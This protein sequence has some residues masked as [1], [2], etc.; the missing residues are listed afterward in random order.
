MTEC[1]TSFIC[2]CEISTATPFVLPG[3]LN[4]PIGPAITI[5]A[6]GAQLDLNGFTLT[7]DISNP[8]GTDMGIL[9]EN[10][11]DVSVYNGFIKGFSFGIQG[12]GLDGALFDNISFET[13]ENALVIFDSEDIKVRNSNFLAS[14]FSAGG[15]GVNLFNVNDSVVTNN[16]FTMSDTETTGVIIDNSKKALVNLNT[17]FFPSTGFIGGEP[18]TEFNAGVEV[19]DSTD[20]TVLRNCFFGPADGTILPRTQGVN[21]DNEGL[22]AGNNDVDIVGNSFNTLD[23][24]IK[25]ESDEGTN[26]SNNCLTN[27]NAAIALTE[28][29][30]DFKLSKNDFFNN[31]ADVLLGDG[32]VIVG[33]PVKSPKGSKK[34]SKNGKGFC[35]CAL[36]RVNGSKSSKGA[37]G[38]KLSKA[39]NMSKAPSK[40]SKII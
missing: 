3:N 40:S 11:S 8:T 24:G 19:S 2:G 1:S 37:K 13:F 6:D 9:I 39:P 25:V 26:M 35:P 32:S 20:V 29:A 38:S 10:V 31:V 36:K 5:T 14:E 4:C 17:F 27:T 7:G 23:I 34:S 33:E 30:T 22:P 21:V 18:E 15:S 16:D 12:S 28:F